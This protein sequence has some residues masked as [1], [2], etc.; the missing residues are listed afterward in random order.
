MV[1]NDR[2]ANLTDPAI[3]MEVKE[4][5]IS[6]VIHELEMIKNA[7]GDI[8]TQLQNEPD[9]N[10]PVIGFKYFFIV[11]ERY[12]EDKII[13]NICNIRWWPY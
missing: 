6:E 3:E 2:L 1:L 5:K 10:H 7:Y 13:K 9:E 11:P 8:E 12:D 4:M